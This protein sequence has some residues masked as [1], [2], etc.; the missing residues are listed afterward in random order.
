MTFPMLLT[1]L[2]AKNDIPYVGV[3]LVLHITGRVVAASAHT[4][5]LFGNAAPLA[6]GRVVAPAHLK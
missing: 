2:Q 1:V 5:A 3:A 6:T 4:D